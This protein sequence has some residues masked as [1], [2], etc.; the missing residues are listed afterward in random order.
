MKHDCCYWLKHT[1]NSMHC[2]THDTRITIDFYT[3][4]TKYDTQ[5]NK[6]L[7]K[8]QCHVRRKQ[9]IARYQNNETCHAKII[10]CFN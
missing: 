4:I 10:M 2:L 8:K 1:I 5:P 9:A 3:S 7:V 6:R